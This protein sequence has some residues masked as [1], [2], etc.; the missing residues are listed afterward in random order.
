M[1]QY[2][3]GHE[4]PVFVELLKFEEIYLSPKLELGTGAGLT[5]IKVTDR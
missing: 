1:V 2:C 4:L 5:N 3:S